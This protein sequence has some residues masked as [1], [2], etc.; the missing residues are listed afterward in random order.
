MNQE[1]MSFFWWLEWGKVPESYSVVAIFSVSSRIAD[2][3]IRTSLLFRSI[4]FLGNF[5]IEDL[6]RTISSLQT[7]SAEKWKINQR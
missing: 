1:M 5:R 6:L 3:Q 2:A 7:N 4:H